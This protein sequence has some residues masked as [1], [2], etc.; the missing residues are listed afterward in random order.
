MGVLESYTTKGGSYGNKEGL[1]IQPRRCKRKSRDWIGRIFLH[2]LWPGGWNACRVFPHHYAFSNSRKGTLF[3]RN[4]N[5]SL[6]CS[7]S[8]RKVKR[9]NKQG[10]SKSCPVLLLFYKYYWQSAYQC[11]NMTR[12]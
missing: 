11:A 2:S 10:C 3:L 7:T 4:R 12:L 9:Q 5:A 8:P 1:V 6:P